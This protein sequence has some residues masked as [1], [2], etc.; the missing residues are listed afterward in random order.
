VRDELHFDTEAV[1]GGEARPNPYHAVTTPIVQTSTY[2]FADTAELVAFKQTSQTGARPERGEYGRYGNPTGWAVEEKAAALEGAEDA[3]LF[4]SGMNAVTTALLGLLSPGDHLVVTQDL[5]RKTRQFCNTFLRRLGVETT[6]VP[7]GDDEA[8]AAALR[9]ETRLIFTEVP[10]NPYL[11]VVDLDWLAE[12]AHAR[13]A[14]LFVDSTFATPY[15]LRPL[16]HGADLVVHSATKYYGGHN[17]LLAG[18]L[19]GP[20]ALIG[21]LRE[22]H[23]MLGGVVDP[24]CAY[25]LLRGLKTLGLRMARHNESGLRLA[26]FLQDHPAVDSVFYP[27]L[28]SH[29]DHAVATR[30]MRG[31]GGVVSFEV[32]GGM[33]GVAAFVDAL[34]LPLIGPSLGGVESLVEQPALM[35]HFELD[36]VERQ[37]IGVSDGLVRYAVGIEDADDLIADVAQALDSV[38]SP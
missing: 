16:V 1:H 23:G 18:L 31:F 36:P 26:R 6:Y 34:R 28:E 12:L 21:E 5:Y 24:G 11:R 27:G 22:V 19:V 2:T 4:A 20:H 29:P 35:S 9:P 32:R 7:M 10:T 15:N 37:A 17:D 8:L 14:R 3:L 30:Q 33:A 13:G 25:L 38:P